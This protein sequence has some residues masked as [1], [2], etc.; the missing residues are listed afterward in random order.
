MNVALLTAAGVGSRMHQ[1]IPKQFIHVDDKPVIIYTMEAFQKHPSIDAIIVVTLESWKDVLWSYAKQFNITKLKWVVAGGDSGQESI[2][3]GLDE[4]RKHLSD[5]DVVMVH[6]GNRPL[7]SSEI[8]SDSL[9]TYKKYGSAVAVIPCTE[10]VFE[11]DDGQSSCKS[12][13]RERLF[14]TQTPHTYR[15]GDLYGAHL[16]ADKRG[17]TN[18]AAS[19][20]LMQELGKMTYFSKGS[21]ENLKITTTDDLKIFKA[22]LHT[23]Q[24]SW[25]K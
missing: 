23:R 14:R 21:E 8:I 2:R 22:L 15:F 4:L 11:S 12:T 24:D 10:V 17:I 3:H 7:V 20:N 19:C 16:E 18:T 9:V 5:D 25:I 1:D 13:P 6:D